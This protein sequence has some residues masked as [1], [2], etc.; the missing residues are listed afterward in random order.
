LKITQLS[1][2]T[3]SV[4][5]LAVFNNDLLASGSRDNTIIIWNTT[6]GHKIKTLTGHNHSVTYLVALLPADSLLLASASGDSSIKIWNITNGKIMN[7]LNDHSDG[8]ACLTVLPNGYLASGSFKEIKIWNITTGKTIINLKGHKSSIFSLVGLLNGLMASAS[9]DK[10]IKIWNLTNN[11][12]LIK[13][14]IGHTDAVTSLVDL[15]NGLLASASQDKTILLWNISTGNINK[16]ISEN[17]ASIDCLFVM[18]DGS[19][20]SGSYGEIKIWNIL[21]GTYLLKTLTNHSESV[22]SLAILPNKNTLISASEDKTINIWNEEIYSFSKNIYKC[23]CSCGQKQDKLSYYYNNTC[24]NSLNFYIC[25]M[26]TSC[27][28]KIIYKGEIPVISLN[29]TKM[30]LSK[31][32][33]FKSYI[34]LS[35]I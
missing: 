33:I 27:D 10:T 30:N 19:L 31:Y 18:P 6:N 8:V 28:S 11:G 21:N 25:F 20:V 29:E 13:N 4:N 32:I 14:L 3:D 16:K 15:P 24:F 23:I 5:A 35:F 34:L 7:S 12:T 17:K 1:G 22:R 9:W 2:H 26:E